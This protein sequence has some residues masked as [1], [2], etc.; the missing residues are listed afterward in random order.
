M[1]VT[2][3]SYENIRILLVKVAPIHQGVRKSG[4]KKGEW[5]RYEWTIN[6][7]YKQFTEKISG[8][9]LII[10]QTNAQNS[11]TCLHT[12]APVL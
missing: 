5:K 7:I 11:E 1:K 4:I 12:I 8:T 2:T 6:T 10:S 9:I 3:I